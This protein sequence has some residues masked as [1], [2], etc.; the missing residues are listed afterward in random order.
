MS[1]AKGTG[2]LLIGNPKPVQKA[3][4]GGAVFFSMP[5][6]LGQAGLQKSLSTVLSAWPRL[7]G[8][9]CRDKDLA[10]FLLGPCTQTG[11]ETHT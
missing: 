7:G 6:V 5:G 10:A 9:S 8:K 4:E 11:F 3:C 2:E 1:G